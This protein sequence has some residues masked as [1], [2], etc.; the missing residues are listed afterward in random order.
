MTIIQANKF[1][2]P[3]WGA[4]RY[5]FDLS[6]WLAAHGQTV[7]PFAM[8]HPDN[9]PTP[10][11][12]YFPSYVRTERVDAREAARHP[13]D[14]GWQALRTAGRMAYSLEARRKLAHLIADTRPD[15]CHLHNVYT[16]ISPSI[17]HTL[18]L[19]HVP[20]VMTV[21]DHH[22]VS[23]QYDRWAPGCGPDVQGMGVLSA[24]AT[25]FHKHSYAASFLQAAVFAF[26]RRLRLYERFVD[27]FLCPSAS[28]AE[29]LKASGFP[30]HKIRVL[31][32]GLD[33]S[34]IRPAYGTGRY[35]LFVG[36]FA[37]VK[38]PETLLDAARL[39][40]WLS[41]RFVGAGPQEAAL[42]RLAQDM[43]NVAFAGYK[44]GAAL[45]EEYAGALAVAMPSRMR[46][47]FGLV[48]LEAMARGKPVLASD[49]GALPEIVE[50][51]FNG[52]LLP[53]L[54]VRAWAEALQRIAVD[55]PFRSSLARHARETVERRFQAE[56]HWQRVLEAYRDAIDVHAS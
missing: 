3:R 32:F 53:P 18:H 29:A 8:A 13:F 41:F 14:A 21:H 31:S 38:G 43:P 10:F 9:F 36:R 11:A 4:D 28:L 48:A 44:T 19:Q 33:A 45:E 16:Q 27:F 26:H 24:A 49:A 34:A 6:A 30:A 37:A 52:W 2:F 22:L 7:I 40:P 47:T 17:L 12:R 20:T 15:V 55:E 54:D 5:V 1:Y 56:E 42:K 51:R 25:R 50:D 39:L 46:E 23:P 35:V